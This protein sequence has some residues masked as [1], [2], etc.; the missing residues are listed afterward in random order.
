[1]WILE[2]EVGHVY[3]YNVNTYHDT[4]DLRDP[5]PGNRYSGGKS[6]LAG[7]HLPPVEYRGRVLLAIDESLA[8]SLTNEI[9]LLTLD[10]VGDGWT[11]VSNRVPRHIDRPWQQNPINAQYN[12][13]LALTKAWISNYAAFTNDVKAVLLVGHV[14]VPYSGTGAED[15]HGDH[16][17]AWPA[18]SFYGDLDAAWPDIL[19]YPIGDSQTRQNLPGDG[20][21]DPNDAFPANSAGVRGL[22]IAVGRVDFA[23][24]S[25]FTNATWLPGYPTNS[26][27]SVEV[28]ILRQYFNKNH[29][30][31]NKT[32]VLP[33]RVAAKQWDGS[34]VHTVANPIASQLFGA[35]P[36]VFLDT[37]I[38][39]TNGPALVGLQRGSG[40]GD[41]INNNSPLHRHTTA[42]LA[43][44]NSGVP[45]AFLGLFGSYFI[46]W[47]NDDN[48]LRSTLAM[49]DYGVAS[50]SLWL[51]CTLGREWPLGDLAIGGTL[52]DCQLRFAGANGYQPSIRTV[53]ILGDPTLRVDPV[54]P[55]TDLV[56]STNQWGQLQMSWTTSATEGALYHLYRST[57][58]AITNATDFVRLTPVPL[59]TSAYLDTTAPSGVTVYMLRALATWHTGGGAFTNM[60]QGLFRTKGI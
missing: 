59:N 2:V 10:L 36:A 35:D 15:N 26:A 38:F 20:K 1:M 52:G 27:E 17:G 16:L 21:F 7:V 23:R 37:D 24:L 12:S 55:A 18:D 11:V 28:G 54:A 31:K 51:H 40:G 25:A 41:A 13:N 34:D 30:F 8:D 4:A 58:A 60:S 19:D 56:F 33:P 50:F 3:E 42:D 39:E 9:R 48:L 47:N 5:I 29:I 14:T 45:V 32:T 46:D 43:G 6:I 49:P 22:D 53:F 57:N 44:R